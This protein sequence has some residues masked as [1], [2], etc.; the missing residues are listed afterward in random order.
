MEKVKVDNPIP[1]MKFPKGSKLERGA[2]AP[3]APA[4]VVGKAGDNVSALALAKRVA[5]D[6]LGM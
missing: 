2:G 3:A 1:G 6:Q 5:A 4:P